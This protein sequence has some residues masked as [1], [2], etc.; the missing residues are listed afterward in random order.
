MECKKLGLR[1]PQTFDFLGFTH[2]WGKGKSGRYRLMRKTSAK[3][4][5]TRVK[6][7]KMWMR[8]NRHMTETQLVTTIRRKLVGHYN[9]YGV[10]DNYRSLMKYYNIV[11][12]YM[13][14][15]LSRRSQKGY[16]TYEKFRLFLDRNPLPPPQIRVNL[17]ASRNL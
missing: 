6:A 1:K 17:F 16:L 8:D 14:K 10:S 3:K 15:W 9:Y 12:A 4:F 7:F 13:R 2:Y 5:R 11:L